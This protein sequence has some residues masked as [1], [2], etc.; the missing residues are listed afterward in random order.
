MFALRG[1]VH[2]A[3]N[4]ASGTVEHVTGI[5]E[6]RT[7]RL[8]D[9]TRVELSVATTLRHP[10]QFP[11][12]GRPVTLIGEAF[13]AVANDQRRPFIKR[14]VKSSTMITSPSWTTY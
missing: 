4:R 10:A 11:P 7:L 12:E 9:G 14:P 1:R 3:W 13:F 8:A 5:G 6:R 2:D